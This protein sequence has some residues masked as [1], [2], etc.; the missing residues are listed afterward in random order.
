[1]K[2][3]FFFR[4]SGN[5]TDKQVHCEKA[6][7]SKMKTQ[8][9]SQAEQEFD[10]P[11]SQGHVSGGPALRRS[12]SWSSAGFLFDKFGETSKN[13]LTSAT[14]S[15]DRRRNHS[16][17]CFTPERQ[18]R[19]RQCEADK[20]QHDSSGSSSSCSSN[21]SSKVLDRYIDGEEHLE[22]CK[23]KSNSSQSG[24]S[25][26]INRRRLPPRVQWT[27]P[28]S[29]SDTSNEKRKSQ[30][31]REAKGT[32]LRFSSAD[33]V[34]NGLRHGSPRSLAR[35]VI[36]RL[37]QTHGKSKGSNHEPI[38]IQDVYGGSLNRTFD[39]SSDIPANVSLAEHYEPVNEYYA[40]DYGG[41]QQN[42]IRG[43]NAYKCM[44]D[45]IDSELEM[46]IKEAEKRAKLFSAE[47]EQ[48]RC[49]SDCDFDV[50]SLVGAIR[51]LEDER[52][53]LAFENVNL[54]RSQMVE[55]ASAREEIRWL[56]SDWDLHIQRLEKEKSELQA[57]LEKEL[58]RRSGEWTS[59]LEKF[60]LEEKKLRER[61]R[62]L[63]EHNVSL[64]R[65]LSAFH[66][67]ETENKDM[68]THLEGRVAELT[69]TADELHEE[70]TY[71]KQTLSQLQ[72]SYEGA[73][74][75]LDFLRRNF[76]EKDQECRELHKSVTKFL[77]TCKEQGKTIEGLRDGVSEEGKKQP[78][79]KLDQLVKKLQV[80]QIRLTG[81]ELSLRREVESMKLE[82]DSLRHEN[83]CLL[84]RL[85]GNGQEI[86][87]TTL[88]LE[89]ELKMRVCYLQDQGLSMLNESSQLCYKL[90]K[91]IK[92]K[93]TQ[94]PET[95]QDKNSVKDG[96]S[97]QFMIESEM[98]VR[99]I[100]RGTENLK[101][102]LQTVTS[103]V[104]S[105]SESSSSST[106]RPREQ[107]NQSVEETLRAELSAE[108]LITSLLRE[109]LYSKEQEIE[110]LQAEVAAA[111]RGNEILRSEVQSS[112]DNLSVTTHEL[113]D[114]KH[115]M[116]KKEESIN[117]LES[118]LQEAAKEMARLN[119]LL[120][121]VSSER[122]EIW[123]DLK[124]CCEKNM[125]LNSE[126]ETLKGM[127]DKLEEKVLE[128]EGE[129]TILQDTIGSKHL[130][131]L[132]SPDFLV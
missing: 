131:L 52:L 132:S 2:K 122:D 63:A 129:I 94:L 99:G 96:L 78:S 16:S 28:T 15:Q 59:K 18:V 46:K 67:N 83:I 32:R 51:K 24:V 97:E 88:K 116:L 48:Q 12:L 81:I 105:N 126:N 68:I 31:F 102:S 25:G 27:V 53:H 110:Q 23:Q 73:T 69:V 125:L 121:K 4:S 38:T 43:K 34:E 3:L 8:A 62:E 36:E 72:E 103:V 20:F 10:S 56:K 91:F 17:R 104:A 49:L 21:V 123:R 64:Q 107:R 37:S 127:V 39:S 113:K 119:A 57:G 80:E 106:G 117:R 55:R 41:N 128:K 7:D 85:K 87:S 90:L 66:E 115:Q 26:S 111:V 124:Q 92:G 50:S 93:L 95:Y 75:D 19:E 6:A 58:D 60:Q 79:E 109:K 71:V 11:K 114:F 5:G 35:N 13:E 76:E 101:R 100:R 42:C 98:K 112:L 29:P 33:C 44:E 84:N 22:P 45:D 130:N 74:E 61:V 47:L 82:T 118:N 9:S 120:S 54:L 1:M 30:S 14:K 70:N 89:N 40:Q 65:E 86:D 77:R 108:T